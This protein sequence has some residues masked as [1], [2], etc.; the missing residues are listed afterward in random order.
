[1]IAAIRRLL[2]GPADLGAFQ[3]AAAPGETAAHHAALLEAARERLREAHRARDLAARELADAK[4]TI[5]RVHGIIRAADVAA[6]EASDAE[7]H[8]REAA[9]AWAASGALGDRPVELRTLANVSRAAQRKADDAK[10]A[11]DGARQAL[12][13]LQ[14][15]EEDAQ[16]QVSHAEERVRS[17]AASVLE[18]IIEPHFAAIERAA[19]II[20]EETLTIEGLAKASWHAT[21]PI[22]GLIVA[23]ELLERLRRAMPA[24]PA[25]D[26]KALYYDRPD[27]DRHP[28]E[29]L[30]QR[31][32]EDPEAKIQ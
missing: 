11:A 23:T 25:R 26:G 8:E 17:A 4:A 18:A 5:E 2:A 12:G 6:Q 31:L 32:I 9:R 30:A 29:R 24:G 3:P 27:V 14:Q 10:V 1:V 22:R 7:M 28:W 16:L 19:Q 13:G 21:S 15:T 20:E